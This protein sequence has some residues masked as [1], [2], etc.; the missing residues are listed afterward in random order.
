MLKT[1]QN[2]RQRLYIVKI[3]FRAELL[4]LR[5][6]KTACGLSYQLVL[7]VGQ[8]QLVW[9]GLLHVRYYTDGTNNE[10]YYALSTKTWK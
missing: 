1:A 9:R 8:L 6:R 10:Y 3:T 4:K 7:H 2:P 5:L